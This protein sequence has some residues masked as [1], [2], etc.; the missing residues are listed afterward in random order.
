MDLLN[1]LFQTQ[2]WGALRAG[3]HIAFFIV[4]V[5]LLK[6]MFDLRASVGLRHLA[7]PRP[8][9]GVAVVGLGLLF[10]GVLAYQA[11]W[12]L[13]GTSRPRFV[14]FM[15]SHDRR[16]FNPAHW[17]ERG[18]ILDHR[19]RVLAESQEVAGEGQVRRS[20][21]YGPGFAHVVGYAHP[22]FGTA[23]MEAAANVSLNGGTPESLLEWGE[24]GR[25][26]ITGDK[27]A[28]GRDLVLTIDAELQALAYQRLGGR[29][30]GVL[31][32]VPGDG[33]VRVLTSSPSF[34]P[35]QLDARLFLGHDPDARLLNR[36]TAGL[37]PPGSTFKVVLAAQSLDAGRPPVLNCPADG[38]TTSSRYPKIRD[39]EYYAARRAG[40]SWGGFGR[41]GLD[42]ALVKSSNV[43][44]AQLGVRQGHEAFRR[45]V[46]RFAF[47][48]RV[49]LTDG[50]SGRQLMRTGR[51]PAIATSDRYGLAQAAIGQGKVLVTPGHMALIAAAIANRGVAPRPRLTVAEP[52][53]VLARFMSADTAMRLARI[54]RRVVTD[55]T[56]RGIDVP[57]LPI[58]GKTG[59]AQNPRGEPHSWFIGFAPAERPALAVAV[60]VEHGGYGSAVAAPIARDLLLRAQERGLL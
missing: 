53:E 5:Y 41:I 49:V 14:A 13:S 12:Q 48:N 50:L 16:Q 44:F 33:A 36:V 9:F 46:A 31:M 55:G 23:G 26:L 20:Y 43:Y 1:A 37:Y 28:K 27:S 4:L 59:T 30:G 34:D 22:R 39:H 7:K 58:A 17:I 60:M 21:P 51:I 45:T 19:G 29:P 32:L 25:Q 47:N 52:P 35:N 8:G 38:F 2:P 3:L 11:S 10:L 54:M 18:R 6:Q 57:G 56:A 42:T 24:L 15:Q 40:R